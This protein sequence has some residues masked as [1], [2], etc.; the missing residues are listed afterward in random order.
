MLIIGFGLH[1]ATE[2]FGIVAPLAAE[3][4]RPSWAFLLAVGLVAGG[5]TFLGTVIGRSWANDALFVAF[6]ALAAGSILYVVMQLVKVAAR[7]G[8][9]DVVMWCIFAGF[10]M[11]LA[12]D[13]VLV[14]A[15]A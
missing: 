5:P 8:F 11:G 1:N 14:A 3:D 4:D 6:L 15:G 13:Y 12:T 7:Q 2:G 10:A 9:E